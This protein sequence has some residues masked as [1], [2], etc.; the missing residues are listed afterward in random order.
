LIAVAVGFGG[1][2]VKPPNH[3]DA[4]SAEELEGGSFV[5]GAV[6]FG[7]WARMAPP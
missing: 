2:E 4:V 7:S 1:V 6:D 3:G 5:K